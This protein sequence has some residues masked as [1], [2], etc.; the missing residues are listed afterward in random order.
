M[1]IDRLIGILS[2]LL[3]EEKVTASYLA[4]IFEVSRRTINRDV[5]ALL[6][7]GIPLATSQGQNGGI[8]IMPAYRIDRTVL[9]SSEMQSILTGLRS[10]DSVA[11]TS[12]YQQLMK[13][14]SVDQ[15]SV[16]VPE[17]HIMINLSS[18]YKSSLSPKIEVIQEAIEASHSIK[19]HYYA[20]GGETER[21]I[22]PYLLVFQ[23]SSWYVWGYCR[24]RK[25][26]RMFKLNRIQELGDTGE[27]CERLPTP[28]FE[29]FPEDPY[30]VSFK[31]TAVCEPGIKWRLIEEFGIGCFKEREDGK[32]LFEAGFSNKDN[33]L[34]W[35]LSM[36]DQVELMEPEE[37]RKDMEEL[38][39][40]IYEKYAGKRKGLLLAES[41][42]E[43][44]NKT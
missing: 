11:G 39:M 25:D 26:F 1:K 37:F 32:L 20:P 10:L 24:D 12:R 4:E 16:Q 21:I 14:L 8:S 2:I 34:G 3:Q 5:E 44:Y 19:F 40:G 13:K 6:R 15:A 18:W 27:H 33:L 17:S 31:V 41:A 35:L 22:D 43:G 38:A 42:K 28:P 36:G 9:T 29:Y 30:P 23:W 7:A